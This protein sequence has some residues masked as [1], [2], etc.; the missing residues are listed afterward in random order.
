MEE[1]FFELD[2]SVQSLFCK[3][4]INIWLDLMMES[5]ALTRTLKEK[6]DT[7]NQNAKIAL[8]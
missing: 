3:T 7:S 2:G 4:T 1:I 6:N 5:L 8:S